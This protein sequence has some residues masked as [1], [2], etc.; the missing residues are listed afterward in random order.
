MVKHWETF[1]EAHAR[2]L[3][4]AHDELRGCLHDEL[5]DCLVDEYH[6]LTQEQFIGAVSVYGTAMGYDFHPNG[7]HDFTWACAD[8][9]AWQR[10]VREK[11]E[12]LKLIDVLDS[13]IRESTLAIGERWPDEPKRKP[14]AVRRKRVAL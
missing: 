7:D 1:E 4:A 14:T 2:A 9:R 10:E 8:K 5:G 11:G 13:C 3:K 6:R 12:Q